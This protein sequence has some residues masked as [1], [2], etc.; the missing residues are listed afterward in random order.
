MRP[1]AVR[2]FPPSPHSSIVFPFRSNVA[3][4][5]RGLCGQ[6]KPFSPSPAATG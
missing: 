4:T 5:L 2:P 1:G 3:S 6:M